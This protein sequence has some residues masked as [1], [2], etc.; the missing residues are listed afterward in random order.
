MKKIL[1][2]L[3]IVLL[4]G[5]CSKNSG[6]AGQTTNG[7]NT[8][9][10][11][12]STNADSGPAQFQVGDTVIYQSNTGQRF[13][14]AKIVSLEGTRARLQS[15]V[16]TVEAE[17]SDVYRVPAA[18]QKVN[19]RAGDIVAARFGQ[20]AVW[21]GAQVVKVG[22]MIT[23]KWLSTGNTDEV[24]P[25]NVLALPPAAAVKVRASFPSAK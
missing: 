3:C 6:E 21:P 5:A 15:Q 25:V 19:V 1:F 16:E 13:Y 4:L 9:A 20:T 7:S 12:S 10:A 23:V 18:G 24:S 11:S 22:D 8:G 14:E 2:L 17:L